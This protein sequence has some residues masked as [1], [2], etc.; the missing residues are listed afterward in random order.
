MNQSSVREQYL[1]ADVFSATPQKLQLLLV[2]A[3]M[4][5]ILR[6]KKYWQEGDIGEAFESLTKAQDIIAEVLCSLDVE[7]SPEIAKKL[8]S[9]YVFIFRRLA[10]AG[11]NQSI[12]KLDDAYRVLCSERETW[13][14]VCEKFGSTQTESTVR[15]GSDISATQQN[16]S[17]SSNNSASLSLSS[18][19]SSRTSGSPLS[20][21]SSG[22]YTP[23]PASSISKTGN[24][25]N[26]GSGTYM[27]RTG[28]IP[29]Q[30]PKSEE[31]KKLSE[32]KPD[33][34]EQNLDKLE[35]KQEGTD[36]VE[37]RTIKPIS[38]FPA[39]QSQGSTGLSWTG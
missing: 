22:S 27:P 3:A 34:L 29:I 18:A 25:L 37:R 11:M 33:N 4:K 14:M 32:Q 35:H 30:K 6:T 1:Q 28:T 38:G 10:E 15:S 13:K 23:T 9:V 16:V 39:Y 21:P 2:E 31:E 20:N 19:P 5:N 24:G 17:G 12:E 8:A 7:G 36:S 26:L